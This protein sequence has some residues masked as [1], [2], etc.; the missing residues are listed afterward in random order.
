[1][2]TQ[3]GEIVGW[4][5]VCGVVSVIVALARVHPLVLPVCF[6]VGVALAVRWLNAGYAE[7]VPRSQWVATAIISA[8]GVPILWFVGRLFCDC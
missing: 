4:F 8:V 3:V 5:V 6:L 2:E 7:P 1:M